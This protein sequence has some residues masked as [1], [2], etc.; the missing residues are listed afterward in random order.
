MWAAGISGVATTDQPASESECRACTVGINFAASKN[1]NTSM[2]FS[3]VLLNTAR[4]CFKGG[5][6][7]DAR[8]GCSWCRERRGCGGVP[9]DDCDRGGELF[10]RSDSI[11]LPA[12]WAAAW[13]A[14]STW[15]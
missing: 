10:S 1:A 12:A 13:A 5:I 8:V 15:S 3:R 7:N 6:P 2:S 14:A 9:L 4:D 11:S